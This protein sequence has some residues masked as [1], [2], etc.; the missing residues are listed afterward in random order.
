MQPHF[1]PKDFKLFSKESISFIADPK[2]KD[3]LR[4]KTRW[5]SEINSKIFK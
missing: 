1:I 3:E 2:K 5:A 4:T